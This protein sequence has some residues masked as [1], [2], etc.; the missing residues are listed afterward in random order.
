MPVP[1]P[2][3]NT[4]AREPS[5]L[6]QQLWRTLKA[7]AEALEQ[8]SDAGVDSYVGVREW[9]DSPEMFV[10]VGR[11]KNGHRHVIAMTIAPA[12]ESN[13]LLFHVSVVHV[14]DGESE[15]IP[16]ERIRV[17]YDVVNNRFCIEEPSVARDDM[18]EFFVDRATALL[19]SQR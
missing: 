4:D 1:N 3:A 9:E 13:Q 11:A 18:A 16:A 2:G 17:S 6:L 5:R 14:L 12:L 10:R 7:Q 15:V 19:L 8:D